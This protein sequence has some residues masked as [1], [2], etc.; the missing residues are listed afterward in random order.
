MGLGTEEG[1]FSFLLVYWCASGS[2]HSKNTI[3]M[4]SRESCF[5]YPW[6]T[7]HWPILQSFSCNLFSFIFSPKHLKW[8]TEATCWIIDDTDNLKKKSHLCISGNNLEQNLQRVFLSL[9]K[10]S[11]GSFHS[12]TY[13]PLTNTSVCTGLDPG[14]QL[15][16]RHI[17]ILK[18]LCWGNIYENKPRPK[19][20]HGALLNCG[21]T[22]MGRRGEAISL[23][24]WTPLKA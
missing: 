8:K 3:N 20:K 24:T 21:D 18:E 14:T 5:C 1:V 6:D 12:L 4:Q 13:S 19:G 9:G 15:W 16:S 2:W 7:I 10:V 23:C 11:S 22:R 17:S